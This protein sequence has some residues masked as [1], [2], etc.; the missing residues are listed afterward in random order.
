MKRL[1]NLVGDR[2]GEYNDEGEEGAVEGSSEAAPPTLFRQVL[3]AV[4]QV[5]V[6]A[7]GWTRVLL[8]R[9]L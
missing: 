7:V 6:A 4:L 3:V 1:Y 9:D 8:S 5:L 2:E